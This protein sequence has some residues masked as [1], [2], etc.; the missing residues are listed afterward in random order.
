MVEYSSLKN[1]TYITL[2][3]SWNI[4][5]EGIKRMSQNMGDMQ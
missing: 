3:G 5:K 1:N 2:Q 4:A